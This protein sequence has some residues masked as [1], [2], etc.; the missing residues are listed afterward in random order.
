MNMISYESIIDKIVIV[1]VKKVSKT[2]HPLDYQE[3]TGS[4]IKANH[5]GIIV[6]DDAGKTLK[7][8]SIL[9]LIKP[10]QPGTY[11]LNTIGVEVHN[12]DYTYNLVLKQQSIDK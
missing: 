1:G 10:A 3:F 5:E 8:P 7:L 6:M 2:G 9:E 12:P 11:K 4:I